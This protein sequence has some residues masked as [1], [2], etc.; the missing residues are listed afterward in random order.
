MWGGFSQCKGQK[1]LLEACINSGKDY[2]RVFFLSGLDYVLVSDKEFHTFFEENKNKEF[3]CGANISTCGEAR[4]ERKIKYYHLFR[5]V[6]FK[7]SFLRTAVKAGV[8]ISLR[9]LGFRKPL[10][11]PV[12]NTSWDVY[13]GSSWSSMTFE[14]AKYVLKQMQENKVVRHYFSTCYAPDELYIPTIVMNSEYGKRAIH[15]SNK[16]NIYLVN[17][18]PLH[19]IT[20]RKFIFTYDENDY[21]MLMSSGKIFVRKLVTGKSE[22]LIEMIDQHN[23]VEAAE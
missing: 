17:V 1:V 12:G 9:L 23:S 18:T 8:R 7:S 21:D 14:C 19:Y 10:S 6:Q 22:K 15:C 4:Q 3:V 2:D 16:E 20:Y 5:D 11:I 13:Y